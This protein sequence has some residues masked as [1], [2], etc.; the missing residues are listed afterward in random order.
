MQKH[1]QNEKIN[2]AQN[3]QAI[4]ISQLLRKFNDEKVSAKREMQA[5][6]K[7]LYVKTMELEKVRKIALKILQER[8]NLEGVL[9]KCLDET[10]QRKDN[11]ES[12]AKEYAYHLNFKQT[13]QTHVLKNQLY[14][15]N[16]L[17][18]STCI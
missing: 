9:Y 1:K 12:I 2:T 18:F 16:V 4:L 6:E 11:Y 8:A 5:L 7:L 13:F 17:Q 14:L 10:F 15:N 3:N